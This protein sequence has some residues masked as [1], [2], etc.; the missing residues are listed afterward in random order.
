MT[1]DKSIA[2][3][4][5]S[6]KPANIAT[7]EALDL[8]GTAPVIAGEDAA[9]FGELLSRTLA[10][11]QPNDFVEIMLVCDAVHLTWESIRYRRL[12]R[13]LLQTEAYEGLRRVLEPFADTYELS[14]LPEAWA[15]REARSLKLVEKLLKSA[16]LSMDEVMAKTLEYKLDRVERIDRLIASAEAR[17]NNALREIDRH[18]AVLGAAVR[19]VVEEAEDA[20]F[21]DVET[22]ET[23]GAVQ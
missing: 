19:A 15:R 21:T 13:H 12:K 16:G 3:Q 6:R 2:E 8:F 17:R 1:Q 10:A 20:E 5:R 14:G 9:A 7:Q 4:P 18:R 11:V 22:S 23:P